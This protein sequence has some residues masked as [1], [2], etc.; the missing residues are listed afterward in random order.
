M[1]PWLARQVIC[2]LHERLLRRTTFAQL[3][4]LEATQW[5]APR[6]IRMLQRRKLGALLVHAGSHSGFYRRRFA[7]AGVDAG[8]RCPFEMLARLPLLDKCTIRRHV[9]AMLWHDA[10]GGLHACS[11]GGSTGAP[12]RFFTDRAR[13]ACDQAARARTH[14]WFGVDVGD[15]ELY[16]WGSPIELGRS[17]RLKRARDRLFNHRLLSAFAMSPEHMD[18][19]LDA[20]ER[21]RPSCLFG[22]PSSVAMLVAHARQRGR[23]LRLRGLR[24]V[25]VTG[26]VCYAH[27]RDAIASYFGVPVAD[28]YGSREAGFIAHECAEGN[29]HIMAEHVVVEIMRRGRPVP[30]GEPGEIVVTHLGAHGM[31][32]IRYRTGDMGRLKPGRCPCGRGLP[33]MDVVEGRTTDYLYFPDGTA[34]HALSVIYAL[35]DVAG[36]GRF[37]VTQGADYGVTVEVVPDRHAGRVVRQAVSRRVRDVLGSDV[38]LRVWLVDELRVSGSG[39][40]RHVVSHAH[41]PGETGGDRDVSV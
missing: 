28:G 13:Q 5:Y 4:S 20:L 12:L 6:E 22:Y 16:L 32:L 23:R 15:R 30:P 40:Y 11:T 26:E 3:R 33:M 1:L 41:A 2:P 34:R 18:G 7:E 25:F 10:P 27:D 39:K 8:D 37:R 36:V 31:P 24:A 9:A 14:R 35:R 38:A 19:Y 21:F 29:M 17:D